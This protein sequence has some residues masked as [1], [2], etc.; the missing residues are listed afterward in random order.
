MTVGKVDLMSPYTL[1]ALMNNMNDSNTP[2]GTPEDAEDLAGLALSDN[3]RRAEV[4]R[5]SNLDKFPDFNGN[6]ATPIRVLPRSNP[7]TALNDSLQHSEFEGVYQELLVCMEFTDE[8]LL[9]YT[10]AE[11]MELR[12]NI[13]LFLANR[14]QDYEELAGEI[15]NRALFKDFFPAD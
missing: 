15:E 12:L 8:E 13:D 9:H 4:I 2:K 11:R 10:P 7:P 6:E 14:G 1:D 5:G 3:A